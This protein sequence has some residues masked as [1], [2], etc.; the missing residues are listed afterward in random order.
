MPADPALSS[1]ALQRVV[2][3]G[4]TRRGMHDTACKCTDMWLKHGFATADFARVSR[5]VCDLS[6]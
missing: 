5:A 2:W 3:L 4:H 1:A 6:L